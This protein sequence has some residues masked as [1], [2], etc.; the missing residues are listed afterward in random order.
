M[1]SNIVVHVGIT[2]HQIGTSAYLFVTEYVRWKTEIT[3]CQVV[4]SIIVVYV[5]ITTY[6]IGIFVLHRIFSIG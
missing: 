5:D 2:T 6:Q 1:N 3:I 4:I